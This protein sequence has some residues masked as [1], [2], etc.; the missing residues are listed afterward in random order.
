MLSDLSVF[1]ICS[2]VLWVSSGSNAPKAP[3]HWVGQQD[4]WT[5]GTG[6]REGTTPKNAGWLTGNSA[7]PWMTGYPSVRKPS[8]GHHQAQKMLS[9]KLASL[10]CGPSLVIPA[11]SVLMGGINMY[12]LYKRS[13]IGA[14]RYW[15]SHIYNSTGPWWPCHFLFPILTGIMYQLAS[16][17]PVDKLID[18]STNLMTSGV[19]LATQEFPKFL[20][21]PGFV[22]KMIYHK[23]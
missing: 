2:P 15:R 16:A 12:K 9:P 3:Q 21:P 23:K 10:L 11:T 7:K 4:A 17:G 19:C 14:L 22:K 20:Q 13:N 18:H 5:G 6:M 8:P 1:D